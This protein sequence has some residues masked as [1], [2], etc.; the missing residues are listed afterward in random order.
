[1]A[2]ITITAANVVPDSGYQR[3]YVVSGATITAGKSCY[4]AVA[5]GRAYLADNNDTAAKAV[6]EGI[7]LNA[8]SAGQPVELMNGGNITIGGTVVVGE[9]Y[10]VSPTAGGIAPEGDL[11][12][13]AYVSLIG[14]GISATKISMVRKNSGV[15]VP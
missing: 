8:A 12:S 4:I 7:A 10:V 9:I 15:Q 6:F 1:M 13:D 11:I 2:D 5:D 14:I 3:K